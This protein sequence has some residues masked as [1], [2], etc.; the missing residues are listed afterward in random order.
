MQKTFSSFLSKENHQF[1]VDY[2]KKQQKY[3]KH[4]SETEND[5]SF[6]FLG[7]IILRCNQPFQTSVYRKT[8]S[9][10]V[11]THYESVWINH[12]R[13]HYW[14]LII[15]P[16]FENLR[17]ILKNKS[18]PSEIREQLTKYFLNKLYIRRTVIPTVAKKETFYN[19]AISWN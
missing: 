19:N 3:I 12:R 6:S 7:I 9:G 8:T 10:E 16:L 1:S 5:N 13:S 11:F 17:E 4:T 15:S 18:Y 2:L 14:Y